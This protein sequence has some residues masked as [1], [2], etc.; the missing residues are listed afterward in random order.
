MRGNE[1]V[2][3]FDGVMQLVA[4]LQLI[5]VVFTGFVVV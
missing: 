4:I 1:D 3:L 2:V 5:D